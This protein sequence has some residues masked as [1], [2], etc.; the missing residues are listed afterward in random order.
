MTDAGW[1]FVLSAAPTTLTL[2]QSCLTPARQR[3][4]RP[5]MNCLAPQRR[6]SSPRYRVPS[7]HFKTLEHVHEEHFEPTHGLR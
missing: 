5:R 1:C 6:Q 4:T 3:Q 2:T 7:D